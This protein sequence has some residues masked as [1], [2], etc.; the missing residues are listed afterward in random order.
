MAPRISGE[1][2]VID[3]GKWLQGAAGPSVTTM[4]EWPGATWDK[5]RKGN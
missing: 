5:L 2:V 1:A 3:G 4:Q